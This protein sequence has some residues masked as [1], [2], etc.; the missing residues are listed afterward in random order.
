MTEVAATPGAAAATPP[1]PPSTPVE[2]ASKLAELRADKGWGEKLLASDKDT[3]AEF[4]SLSKLAAQASD[5]DRVMAGE[6]NLPDINIEGRLSL[7]KVAGEIPALKEAGISEGAIREMLE[8][9][10]STP[11]EIDFA[12]RFKAMRHSDEGW[13]KR[14]LSGQHE[15]VREARLISMILLAAPA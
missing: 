6:K 2:A 4:R 8:G 5:V 1:A 3:L 12:T 13:I 14:Y 7:A 11:E 15:A 10:P 9:R